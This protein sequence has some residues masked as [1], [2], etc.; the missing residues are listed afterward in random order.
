ML[1]TELKGRM[2]LMKK[3]KEKKKKKKKKKKKGLEAEFLFLV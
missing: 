3:K 2:I 1:V